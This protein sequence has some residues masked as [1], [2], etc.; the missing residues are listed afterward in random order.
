VED[1]SRPL[2]QD[3]WPDIPKAIT[4]KDEE[5][6]KIKQSNAIRKELLEDSELDLDDIAK[7]LILVE[8]TGVDDAGVIEALRIVLQKIRDIVLYKGGESKATLSGWAEEAIGR[9]SEIPVTRNKPW[10]ELIDDLQLSNFVPD[11]Y[12][13]IS[14]MVQLEDR[15]PAEIPVSEYLPLIREALKDIIL[16]MAECVALLQ[17]FIIHDAPNLALFLEIKTVEPKEAVAAPRK[18]NVKSRKEVVAN[19]R[20][21]GYM[22][23]LHDYAELAQ[24]LGVL[25]WVDALPDPFRNG[26]VAEN[27]NMLLPK[28]QSACTKRDAVITT[29]L[30]GRYYEIR[31]ANPEAKTPET[32]AANAANKTFLAEAEIIQNSN[33]Q[34]SALIQA[35]NFQ[36]RHQDVLQEL[37]YFSE[38]TADPCLDTLIMKEVRDNLQRI[39]RSLSFKD[40][41]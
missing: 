22:H 41:S 1:L 25:T 7:L 35:I 17:R 11:I 24:L 34:R 30:E 4:E 12:D 20:G 39:C 32:E 19:E 37:L 10:H 15:S 5:I 38:I 14:V 21:Y 18:K 33:S 8:Y 13:R 27:T 2:Y 36:P 6:K 23:R 31:K 3:R 26:I 9:P 16:N 28:M 40:D 29:K